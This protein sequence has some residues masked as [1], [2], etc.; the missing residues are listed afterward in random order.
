M[1]ICIVVCK[2]EGVRAC[3]RACVC[4]CMYMIARACI[5][6]YVCMYVCMYEKNV[7]VCV[8]GVGACEC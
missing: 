4:A 1:N 6:S 3:V 2:H 7:G 8:Y 5:R